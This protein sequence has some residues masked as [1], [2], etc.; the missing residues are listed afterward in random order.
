VLIVLSRIHFAYD[1]A[2]LL[3]AARTALGKA[4]DPL[5]RHPD[6]HLFLDGHAD[7]RGSAEYNRALGERRARSVAEQLARL[8]VARDRLHVGSFGKDQP[9]VRGD[10]P[11]A[12]AHNR[13]VDFRLMRGDVRLVLEAGVLFDDVGHELGGRTGSR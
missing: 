11:N 7:L 12:H 2:A 1:S 10:G 5:T 6:V 3:P 13:R 4:A 9:L 8:G